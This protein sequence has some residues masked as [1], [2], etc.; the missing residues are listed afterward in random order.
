MRTCLP[1]YIQCWP[2][3]EPVYGAMYLK[4]AGSDAGLCTIVVYARAPALSRV[5]RTSAIVEPF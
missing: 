4:P 5:P 3:A 1:S 2:M